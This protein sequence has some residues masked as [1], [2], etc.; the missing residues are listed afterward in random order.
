VKGKEQVAGKGD[1]A[2][3]LSSNGNGDAAGTGL[4]LLASM[5]S[6]N[7]GQRIWPWSADSRISPHDRASQP[8]P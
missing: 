4:R 8:S 3:P 5:T 6:C 7:H 2:A 1:R